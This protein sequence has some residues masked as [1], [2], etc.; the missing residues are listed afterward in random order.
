MN[1]PPPRR[2]RKEARPAELLAAALTLFVERG[3][4]AT[5]L[6]DIAQRAGVS[7][8]TLYL[9][10]DNKEALFQAVIRE[11]ILPVVAEN[12]AIAA[13]HTGGSFELLEKLLDNWWLRIGSTD[14]SGIPKLMVS[15]AMNFPDT[16][17][18]YYEHVIARGRELIGSALRR[19]IAAGEFRD[20]PVD[21]A[22]DVIIAP[23][24]MLL[25]WNHSL[26]CCQDRPLDSRS[27]LALHLDLLRHALGKPREG[28]R[29]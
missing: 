21:T 12:E 4:A 9:Y 28:S 22:I 5:R 2:R 13:R 10:Y 8:G 1:L 3:F 15:E 19:G 29:V 20:L 24:L 6:E 26:G 23:L 16:A 11:G 25:I 7:K 18:F 14:F 27:Y 17:R